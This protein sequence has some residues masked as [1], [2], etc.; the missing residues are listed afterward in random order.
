MVIWPGGPEFQPVRTWAAEWKPSAL[1]ENKRLTI[2]KHSRHILPSPDRNRH[3][4]LHRPTACRRR[5]L[6]QRRRLRLILCPASRVAQQGR[7]EAVLLAGVPCAANVGSLL[8]PPQLARPTRL[9]RPAH[10]SAT[11]RH[12]PLHQ[13][14]PLGI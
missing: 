13:T 4:S 9:Q 5:R 11:E 2:R 10:G 8:P 6:S 7:L 14:P 12:R 3:L 1:G